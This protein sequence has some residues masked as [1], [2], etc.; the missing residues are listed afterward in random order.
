MKLTILAAVVLALGIVLGLALRGTVFEAEA[1]RTPS[2]PTGRVIELGTLPS[3]VS[4]KV[5]FPLVDTRDCSEM[6]A[7]ATA[8]AG[9]IEFTD[10]FVSVNGSTTFRADF[11]TGP[12]PSLLGRGSTALLGAWPFVQ[13]SAQ[14][15]GTATNITAWIWC[16]P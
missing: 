12:T 11:L 2:P 3:A 14:N 9:G 15:A 1:A 8:P 6:S 7:V 16:A 13:L 4:E 5:Q 10:L